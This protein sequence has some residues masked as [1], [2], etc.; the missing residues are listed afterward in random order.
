MRSLKMVFK[1]YESHIRIVEYE[2]KCQQEM[3]SQVKVWVRL[4]LTCWCCSN[5]YKKF[6]NLICDYIMNA[7]MNEGE[8]RIKCIT[9]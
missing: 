4:M 9:T 2:M 8:M 7:F 6:S 1:V 5:V 3:V